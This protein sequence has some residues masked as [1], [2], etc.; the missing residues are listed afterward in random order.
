MGF[1]VSSVRAPLQSV[2]VGKA[3]RKL[4]WEARSSFAKGCARRAGAMAGDGGLPSAAREDERQGQLTSQQD[5][6]VG[7]ALKVRAS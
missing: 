3:A 5:R 1:A 4:S 7:E 2:A 6:T